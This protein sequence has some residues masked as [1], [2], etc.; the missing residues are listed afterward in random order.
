ML[1]HAGTLDQ[2]EA[3]SAFAAAV[4]TLDFSGLELWAQHEIRFVNLDLA[5]QKMDVLKPLAKSRF[6]R[7]CVTSVWH[8]QSATVAER[9]LLRAFAGA[10]DC[11]MP[12]L[13][14]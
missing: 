11:P 1:A 9:E 3:Q 7:A 12:P 2:S 5:L 14:A 13:G 6:I 4:Q 8:D 10:L